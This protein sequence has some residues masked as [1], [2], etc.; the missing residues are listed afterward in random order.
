[1]GIGLFAQGCGVEA[2]SAPTAVIPTPTPQLLSIAGFVVG[3]EPTTGQA[4][5]IQVLDRAGATWTFLI[6]F[7]PGWEVPAEHLVEHERRRLPVVV[8]YRDEADG[9]RTAARIED[10]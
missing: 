5:R 9:A 10:G 1:M 2:D 6:E 4:Q 3:V 8:Y 7:E